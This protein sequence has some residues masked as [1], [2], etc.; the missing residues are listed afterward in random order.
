MTL[1]KRPVSAVSILAVLVMLL[2]PALA[3]MQYRWLGQL[4]DGRARAHAAHA[5]HR[6]RAVRDRVRHRAVARC[7]SACRS[8]AR[9]FAT[10][11]GPATRSATPLDHDRRRAAPRARRVAGRHAA[12][13]AAAGA[14]MR[15]QP[16]PVDRLRL[17][18]WNAQALTFDDAAEWPHDLVARPRFARAS[19]HRL[20]GAAQPARRAPVVHREAIVSLTLGDDTT[21]DRAGDAVRAARRRRTIGQAAEDHGARLHRS[22]GSSR[23]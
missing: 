9:R 12:G 22:C 2:V 5:A 14:W 8:T 18:R 7:S 15:S 6:R 21:L 17:R 20:H 3:W 16:I 11:T 4:S 10:R 1:A 19:L 23:R 13:H